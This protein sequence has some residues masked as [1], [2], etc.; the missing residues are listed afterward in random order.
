MKLA[1]FYD[2]LKKMD[3]YWGQADWQ[4][5]IDLIMASNENPSSKISYIHL[6]LKGKIHYLQEQL[7][8]STSKNNDTEAMEK[9]KQKL[10]ALCRELQ[11]V[12][13]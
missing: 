10:Q 3:K 5:L 9:H 12:T 6:A 8:M 13:P 4:G 2:K 7:N 11:T 1:P